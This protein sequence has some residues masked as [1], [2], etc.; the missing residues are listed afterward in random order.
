M[1]LEKGISIEARVPVVREGWVGKP[2]GLKQVAWERG[3][4]DPNKIK[5]YEKHSKDKSLSLTAI[6]NACSDFENEMSRAQE[7]VEELGCKLMVSPKYLAE[8]AGERIE[9][10]WGHSK[11]DYRRHPTSA[12]NSKKAFHLLVCFCTSRERLTVELVRK[13]AKR[14][15]QFILSY[16]AIESGQANENAVRNERGQIVIASGVPDERRRQILSQTMTHEDIKRM[17]KKIKTHRCILDLDYKFVSE[18]ARE[19]GT[20]LADMSN[21]ESEINEMELV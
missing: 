1:A 18:A 8:L 20:N 3:L 6:V 12:K 14:A 5:S 11:L 17:V 10:C 15:R 9:Y 4:L 16:W 7:L 19:S 21:L 13:M 2:K